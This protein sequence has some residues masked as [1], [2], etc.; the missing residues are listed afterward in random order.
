MI[1]LESQDSSFERAVLYGHSSFDYSLD[2]SDKTDNHPE[3]SE[4]NLA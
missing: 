4:Q 2:Q 1:C 3:V